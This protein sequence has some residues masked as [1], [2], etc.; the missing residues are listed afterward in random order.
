MPDRQLDTLT[1]KRLRR[2][3]VREASALETWRQAREELV[4]EIVAL[5][6]TTTLKALAAATGLSF[7][8]I[9]QIVKN[10]D[11]RAPKP[12]GAVRTKRKSQML[13]R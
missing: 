4:A 9:D 6:P 11:R 1:A 7:Q 5:R 10:P 3:V 2:K 13:R 12:R 8:R